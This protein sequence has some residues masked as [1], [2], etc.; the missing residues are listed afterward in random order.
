MFFD[1]ID[2]IASQRGSSTWS[3]GDVMDNVVNQLLTEMQGIGKRCVCVGVVPLES[4]SRLEVLTRWLAVG[5]RNNVFIVGATN[6]PGNIDPAITRPGRLDQ[7]IEIGLPDYP[8]RIGIFR[9]CLRKT[10]VARYV[11]CGVCSSF[12]VCLGE[13]WVGGAKCDL[14]WCALGVNTTRDIDFEKIALATNGY[15]GSDIRNICNN[16]SKQSVTRRIREDPEAKA[17]TWEIT[18]EDFAIAF[19][20]VVA[21]PCVGPHCP[22]P[23]VLP[24]M[25]VISESRP[26]LTEADLAEYRANAHKMLERMGS[27]QDDALRED[28][29][30]LTGRYKLVGAS[31]ATT[32]DGDDDD[33]M[34]DFY[35]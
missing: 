32:A 31:A 28:A 2:S 6:K 9:A 5:C 17:T 10:P 12:A 33:D 26:S 19:A 22:H 4:L 16:A 29:T 13:R 18:A 7:P 21:T 3:S 24:L 11:L 23:L 35:A 34:G 30:S 15:T 8:A 1:E 25:S 14:A 20:C 27:T